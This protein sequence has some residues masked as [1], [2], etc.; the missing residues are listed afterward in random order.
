[1]EEGQLQRSVFGK[2]DGVEVE[3]VDSTVK[4]SA[5]K[6]GRLP[7][8]VTASKHSPPGSGTDREG[9]DVDTVRGQ[10]L[11]I[12]SKVDRGDGVAG[13][14]AAARGGRAADGEGPAEQD[15]GA[16]DVAGRNEGSDAARGDGLAAQDLRGVGVDAE[17]EI[18]AEGFERVHVRRGVATEAEGFAF[19]DLAHVDASRRMV[20]AKSSAESC[21]SCSV[22]GTTRVASM[23]VLARRASFCA[24]GV[25]REWGS[26]GRR[27]RTGW[28]SKVMTR[29]CRLRVR[30]RALIWS[31][32]QPWPRC[33][34]SKLPMVATTGPKSGGE[35]VE[36]GEDF[37]RDEAGSGGR[38]NE[39]SRFAS[40][41]RR[42]LAE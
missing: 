25:M 10:E 19:V 8:L 11:G 16:R 14:V 1:M 12:G 20:R 40:P 4:E 36:G 39:S 18:P 35:C 41:Q 21:E 15:A 7:T 38:S 23:P 28:G 3:Q 22:K 5:P 26:S 29:E 42:P 31:M 24:S 30:A 13:S 27:T 34:P 32:T 37:H 9:G 33:T 6:V 17:I 2:S